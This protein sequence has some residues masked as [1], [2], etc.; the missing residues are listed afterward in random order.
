MHNKSKW[1][2]TNT[3]AQRSSR[4][5]NFSKL[6][7]Y[8]SRD[9]KRTKAIKNWPTV[10]SETENFPGECSSLHLLFAFSIAMHRFVYLTRKKNFFVLLQFSALISVKT[11]LSGPNIS[12]QQIKLAICRIY[13]CMN[14]CIE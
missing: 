4:C 8:S 13:L 1:N 5:N 14:K 10:K 2:Q 6:L 7:P 3:V 9:V 11:I 12:K